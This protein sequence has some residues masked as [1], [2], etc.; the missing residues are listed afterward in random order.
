M[1]RLFYGLLN[2][3]LAALIEVF[4]VM[5][6]AFVWVWEW[7]NAFTVFIFVYVPFFVTAM[8]AYD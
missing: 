7:W 2:A 3:A 6:P 5:T 8:Y 4:L 1:N